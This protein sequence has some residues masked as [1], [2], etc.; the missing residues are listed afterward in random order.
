MG[1]VRAY[2]EMLPRLQAEESLLAV[3]RH[4][5]GAGTATKASAAKVTA[6]WERTAAGV[7]VGAPMTIG[8][9]KAMGMSYHRVK[10]QA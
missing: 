5:I 6:A 8:R 7:P 1:L 3:T 2:A 9:M 4:T 10:R